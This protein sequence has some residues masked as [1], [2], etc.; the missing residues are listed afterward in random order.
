MADVTLNGDGSAKIVCSRREHEAHL[1]TFE[2]RRIPTE[3]PDDDPKE[4]MDYLEI[5][6]MSPLAEHDLLDKSVC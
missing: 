5:F 1:E 2:I 3:D 4:R 6:S